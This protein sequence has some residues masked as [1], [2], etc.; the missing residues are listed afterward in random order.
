MQ[1]WKEIDIVEVVRKTITYVHMKD[2]KFGL[3]N[4]GTQKSTRM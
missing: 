2:I 3:R 4:V 1:K